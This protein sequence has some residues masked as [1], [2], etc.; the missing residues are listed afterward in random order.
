V[1][2]QRRKRIRRSEVG[3]QSLPAVSLAGS[4]GSDVGAGLYACPIQESE[5]RRSEG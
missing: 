1:K 5:V 2:A 4:E 3:G